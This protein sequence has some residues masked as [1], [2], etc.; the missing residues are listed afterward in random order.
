MRNPLAEL[1]GYKLRRAAQ[2][3]VGLLADRLA[4]IDLR[5]SEASVMLMVGERRDITAS[6]IGRELDIQRANM[7]PLLKR[8]EQAGLVVRN[9]IDRKSSAI[10]L[11]PAGLSR[12][13]EVRTITASFEDELLARVPSRHREHLVPILDALL[14]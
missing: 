12:L 1:P 14:R 13:S 7:V 5:V 10:V 8:L 4:A 11:T 2:T 3:Q 6:E 9:P